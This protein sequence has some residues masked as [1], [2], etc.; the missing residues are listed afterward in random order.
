VKIIEDHLVNL[1]LD[2][3]NGLATKF[4]PSGEKA[5]ELVQFGREF[6]KIIK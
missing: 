4:Y 5:E 1:K 6:G 2:V 3:K